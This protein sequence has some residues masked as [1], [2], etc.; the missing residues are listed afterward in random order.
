MREWIR[1]KWFSLLLGSILIA[2]A[3]AMVNGIAS[4]SLFL[5]EAF[6]I[7]NVVDFP[8]GYFISSAPSA[9]IFYSLSYLLMKLLGH[10]EWVFRLM[11]FAC[12]AA[13][14]AMVVWFLAGH[15]S[16]T[17][18]LVSALLLVGSYPLN[19]YASNAHP[20]TA[21]FLC[22]VALCLITYSLLEAYSTRKW[23]GFIAASLVSA[24]F[25]FPSLFVIASCGAVLLAAGIRGK[26][27][28]ILR[29]KLA[30]L[31]VIG[32]AVGGLTLFLYMRQSVRSDLGYWAEFFP[33][34]HGLS[35]LLKF[36]YFGTVR[37]FGYLF[38]FKDSGMAGLIL[39]VL[40][41][42]W[43][44]QNGRMLFGLFCWMPAGLA[45]AASLVRK[46]PYGP[47]R[48]DLFLMP[49]LLIL[50]AAGMEWIRRSAASKLSKILV[51]ASLLLLLVPQ[52][53]MVK[54]TFIPVGDPGEAV[55]TLS[56]EVKP[57]IRE[58]DVFL[59]Y[60]GAESE[61]RYYFSEQVPRALFQPWD[62]KGDSRALGQFVEDSMSG[63]KGRVWIV[64][65]YLTKGDDEIMLAAAGRH[66]T[67]LLSRSA[68]DCSA[69]LFECGGR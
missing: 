66:G 19:H 40:G 53:W 9:P 36:G 13:G 62:A 50:M 56:R 37:L 35:S 15:F 63:R 24:L 51:T 30:G 43:F 57:L 22:A 23:I 8:S 64:F 58:G 67:A 31:A 65:C 11:P 47:V 2:G 34:G 55:K 46:W 20:F 32:L 28:R 6:F 52:S 69:H 33:A 29:E 5:D 26:N 42:A 16:K 3:L 25:S 10:S 18:A 60:Y 39:A 41:T 48:T 38:F 14:C 61:F 1:K 59:V 44:F 4:K 68:P 7:R 12:A 21:D 49:F 45:M 27:S 17:A 54:K